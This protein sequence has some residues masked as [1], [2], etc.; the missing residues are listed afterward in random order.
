MATKS[1]ATLHDVATAAKVSIA[2]ASKALNG[3]T[4][5]AANKTRVMKAAEKLG[6]VVNDTA[7]ALRSNRSHTV[8]LIFSELSSTRGIGL[9][10][11][12]S[13]TLEAA[14]YSLICATARADAA[15][16]DRLM[17]RFLERRVD[18]IFC[19]SP[20]D[21]LPSVARY[22]AAGIPVV[23]VTERSKALATQ[24]FLRPSIDA[25]VAASMK[26]ILGFGHRRVLSIDD[27]LQRYSL[28]TIDPRLTQIISI[29]LRS[30]LDV[31]SLDELVRALQKQQ[32][33]PTLISAFQPQAE[34]IMVAC[35]AIGASVPGDFSLIALTH[36]G[37]E[38]RAADMGMS[39]VLFRPELLGA[40]AA[41][42]MLLALE[43]KKIPKTISVE[44]GTWTR[45]ESVGQAN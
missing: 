25:A 30:L 26:D 7:R 21:E 24:P 23:V 37:N 8:G 33:K 34:A 40:E 3:L 35:R 15:A 43:D 18:G 17:R 45:R 1:K 11:A 10:D 27:G 14:G 28:N 44:V 5:S 13:A 22:Q 41:K 36:S 19:V 39:S 12:M 16:Y 38:K 4:V 9:L 42:Q 29:E 32:D 31:G 20:P 2:T 6:Y